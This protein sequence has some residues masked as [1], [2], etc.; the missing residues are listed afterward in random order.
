VNCVKCVNT[1]TDRETESAA[2]AYVVFETFAASALSEVDSTGLILI[3][4][5]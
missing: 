5:E 1:A 2:P 3:A 4:A